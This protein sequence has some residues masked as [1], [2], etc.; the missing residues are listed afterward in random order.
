[1][2]QPEIQEFKVKTCQGIGSKM[3][4]ERL[5]SSHSPFLAK[6]DETVGFLRRAAGKRCDGDEIYEGSA[7]I[8]EVIDGGTQDFY[9]Q[10]TIP[11]Y[12]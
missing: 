8:Q 1:V 12:Y 7:F 6:P 2:F 4:T 11:G 10:N 5:F 3:E 9:P